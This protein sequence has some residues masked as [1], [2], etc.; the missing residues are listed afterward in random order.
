M[1]N[2]NKYLP[3]VSFI[4]FLIIQSITVAWWASGV[5]TRQKYIIERVTIL[6]RKVEERLTSIEKESVSLLS[7]VT[8]VESNLAYVEKAMEDL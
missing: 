3:I 8:L 5:T 6:E 1:A 4:I 7:R 2:G